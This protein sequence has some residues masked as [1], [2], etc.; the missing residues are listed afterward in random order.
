M[1]LACIMRDPDDDELQNEV[2]MRLTA[3]AAKLREGANDNEAS[4][5]NADD[6]P[7]TTEQPDNS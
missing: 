5:P 7:P 2:A 4:E 1:R 3:Y 6:A